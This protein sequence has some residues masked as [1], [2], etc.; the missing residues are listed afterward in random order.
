MSEEVYK[1]ILKRRSIRKF[2]PKKIPSELLGK[3]VNAGRVAPSAANLQPLEYIAVNEDT[4]L[5]KLFSLVKFAGYID[6]NPTEEEMPRAY[7]AVLAKK[8]SKYAP[9]DV[10]LAAENII[11]SALE[12]GIGSCLIGAFK[13]EDIRDLLDVP[14][15]YNIHLLLALGYPAEDPVMEEL[16]SPEASIKYWKDDKDTLHVPKRALKH[17]LHKDKFGS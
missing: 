7:I 3:F 5:K 13:E 14:Q 2:N 1:T 12:E 8:E 9:Y 10:G 6:W 15:T 4:L 16:D 17:I 11:L